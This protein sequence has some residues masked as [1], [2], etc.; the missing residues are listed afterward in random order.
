MKFVL[1]RN[2]VVYWKIRKNLKE[3]FKQHFNYAKGDGT[4]LIHVKRFILLY[5]S[6]MFLLGL[7]MLFW[8]K[9]LIWITIASLVLVGL[10]YKWIRKVKRKSFRRIMYGYLLTL[11]IVLGLSIGYIAGLINRMRNPQLRRSLKGW[12]SIGVKR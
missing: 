10:W 3:I 8:D 1:A 5:S 2:A 6:L 12:W 9:L 7:I 11:A 4:A